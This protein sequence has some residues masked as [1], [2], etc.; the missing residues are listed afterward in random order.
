MF[1]VNKLTIHIC[2]T[3][4]IHIICHSTLSIQ[5]TYPSIKSLT[6]NSA[7]SGHIIHPACGGVEVMNKI[8]IQVEFYVTKLSTSTQEA[9]EISMITAKK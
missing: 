6:T 8:A 7:S 2:L 5:S 9:T 1:P 3:L 4:L